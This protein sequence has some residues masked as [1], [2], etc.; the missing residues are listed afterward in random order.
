MPN[1][2]QQ[3]RRNI[4][5]DILRNLF[6]TEDPYAGLL[7]AYG[8]LAVLWPLSC[9]MLLCVPFENLINRLWVV[10]CTNLWLFPYAIALQTVA[11]CRLLLTKIQRRWLKILTAILLSIFT[12]PCAVVGFLFLPYAYRK[13]NWPAVGLLSASLL[14]FL[15]SIVAPF[16]ACGNLPLNYNYIIYI[17]LVILLLFP[18]FL[19]PHLTRRMAFA[20][21]PLVV[22]ALILWQFHLKD[23]Q[24]SK[25]IDQERKAIGVLVGQPMALSDYRARVG[26]GFS[27]EDEPLK[28]L[29]ARYKGCNTDPIKDLWPGIPADELASRYLDFLRDNAEYVQALDAWLE[30]PAQHIAHVWSDESAYGIMLP[31]LPSFR[32]AAWFLALKMRVNFDSPEMVRQCN[33]GMELLRDE[34]LSG[35]TLISTLVGI[36]IESI[37]LNALVT[38]LDNAHWSREDWLALVGEEPD[39]NFHVMKVLADES[40]AFDSCVEYLWNAPMNLAR[41]DGDETM[42]NFPAKY[43]N[44]GLSLVHW[45][46]KRDHCFA[47]EFYR[48]NIELL[49]EIPHPYGKLNE[50]HE[51]SFKTMRE[52]LYILSAMLLPAL[53]KAIVK[54]D[55]MHDLRVQTVM[56]WEIVHYRDTHGGQLPETLDFLGEIPVSSVTGKPFGYETGDVPYN[57][58]P[59]EDSRTVHGFRLTNTVYDNYPKEKQFHLV[60]PL[61]N[62]P[63]TH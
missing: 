43:P 59:T 38:T 45:I 26:A 41:L 24:L 58:N 1:E 29:I 9:W 7:L 49:Q 51:S 30:L 21:I 10:F 60:V 2:S 40:S 33:H 18:L 31:E 39:W 22:I 61:A 3:P 23:V 19:A 16:G 5:A 34:T 14:L 13:R 28:S 6:F 25:Q 17:Q 46:L 47:L 15:V 50:L 62:G 35:D 36:A 11:Y 20:L 57:I 53:D 48:Q 4:P 8:I 12:V 27:L 42:S 52:Q 56:A 32:N 55:N 54:F 63:T 44:P 37:R